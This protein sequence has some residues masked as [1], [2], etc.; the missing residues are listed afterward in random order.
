MAITKKGWDQELMFGLFTKEATFDAGVTMND[1]NS[2]GMKGFESIDVEWDD[3]VINDKEEVTGTEHGTDQEINTQGVK[4]SYKEPRAKPN[5]VAGLA[6][7]ALG[8]ITSTQDG[9]EVAYKHKIVPVGIG[10]ALPSI[11]AEH[12]KGG[13]QYAY[14]GVKAN[15]FKLSGEAGGYVAMES[16]LIGSGTRATSAT[17]FTSKISESW[18]KLSSANIWMES[19]S[20]IAITGTLVQGAEDISSA[21]PDDLGVRIKSFEFSFLSNLEKQ[22]GFGGAGVA[23][24]IDYG[25][26]G[27]EFKFQLL[28]SGSTEL[29]Y[30]MNQN[31]MAIE[32]D[33]KGAQITGASTMYFGVQIIIPR[34]KM[35]A[36]PLPTGGVGDILIQDIDCDVQ[37]DGTN[38]AC[39]IEVYN[40]MPAYLA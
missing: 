31:P 18:L 15:S 19:G 17:S 39:I 30:Y 36:P 3:E 26:R 14:K 20:D 32:I 24:D 1:S 28:F 40:A 38:D 8:S 7:L 22:L 10:T 29:D 6:A 12:K 5:S 4:F 35:K 37:D 33:L 25:R 21:T 2:C 16:E 9:V 11:Q 23:Q 27:I 34:F 13:L